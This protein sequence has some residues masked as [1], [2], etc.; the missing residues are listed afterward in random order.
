[1]KPLGCRGRSAESARLR[2]GMR[3]HRA[4]LFLSKQT[5][6]EEKR[7]QVQEKD[8]FS[9]PFNLQGGGCP[10]SVCHQPVQPLDPHVD[11]ILR[12]GWGKCIGVGRRDTQTRSATQTSWDHPQHLICPIPCFIPFLVTFSPPGD[13]LVGSP[14]MG[15]MW[16]AGSLVPACPTPSSFSS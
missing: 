16:L 6:R 9:S 1:M 3:C 11:L 12:S 4:H 13:A 7:K 15:W 2:E 5:E 8:G 14:P 10:Q